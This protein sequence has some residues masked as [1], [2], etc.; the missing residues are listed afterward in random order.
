MGNKS[1]RLASPPGS[2]QLPS[3]T[4]AQCWAGSGVREADVLAH[5][6]GT[7]C[8]LA[9][10]LGKC[11]THLVPGVSHGQD[12]PSSSS[13]LGIPPG[14]TW[15]AVIPSTPRLRS[16]RTSGVLHHPRHQSFAPS[17]DPRQ[18]QGGQFSSL[19]SKDSR[20]AK[21]TSHCQG[22]LLGSGS[23]QHHLGSRRTTWAR[24]APGNTLLP[25][26][27]S[28]GGSQRGSWGEEAE[29]WGSP[30]PPCLLF[31]V[32]SWRCSAQTH[33]LEQ[34]WST[35][36]S[37]GL[38]NSKA[39][40]CRQLRP[41]ER[42]EEGRIPH[43]PFQRERGQ[44][45]EWKCQAGQETPPASSL[46]AASAR[47]EQRTPACSTSP[48]CA[49]AARSATS[50]KDLMHFTFNCRS[51]RI[52]RLLPC[53]G[54]PRCC[55]GGKEKRRKKG[56]SC[57]EPRVRAVLDAGAGAQQGETRR[58]QE[59]RDHRWQARMGRDGKEWENNAEKGSNQQKEMKG[60]G[61]GVS[62]TEFSSGRGARARCGTVFWLTRA[63]PTAA[64]RAPAL[65]HE[66]GT[67]AA[68]S[69]SPPDESPPNQAPIE[70]HLSTLTHGSSLLPQQAKPPSPPGA[71]IAWVWHPAHAG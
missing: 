70:Q 59:E 57:T 20:N 34:G 17:S 7:H 27:P 65:E 48:P 61:S 12:F 1:E 22:S 3:D 9:M 68:T 66:P 62:T 54:T 50:C 69:P 23:P 5:A 26:S 60:S 11:K 47:R 4:R 19:H 21:S 52:P 16:P 31:W 67:S 71:V 29:I 6:W 14:I 45:P 10:Q 8:L 30:S 63:W 64:P 53:R 28:R 33:H 39:S 40:L 58:T 13:C 18:G 46:Q 44:S 32:P 24:S 56:H 51:Q 35:A 38:K 41:E 36:R 25:C 15:H 43:C 49:A 2:Q 37:Q 55:R 42:E